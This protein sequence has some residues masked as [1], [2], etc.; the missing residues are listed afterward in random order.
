MM[1]GQSCIVIFITTSTDE[2]AKKIANALL[3]KEKAA[4]VNII[5]GIHSLFWWQGKIDSA[6]EALLMVKTRRQLLDDVIKLVKELHSYD[7]PEI[8]ALPI[9]GGSEEYLEWIGESVKERR[10]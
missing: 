10:R 2:Q 1:E 4:C 6:S 7:L 8:I 9:I 5:P 3:N